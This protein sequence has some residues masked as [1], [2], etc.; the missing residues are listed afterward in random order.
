MLHGI[1]VA[2]HPLLFLGS[3]FEFCVKRSHEAVILVLDGMLVPS[4][5]GSRNFRPL[6]TDLDDLLEQRCLL[7]FSPCTLAN[8]G[9]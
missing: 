7:C 8:I 1:V 6:T 2:N 4:R 9:V 3:S 5:N